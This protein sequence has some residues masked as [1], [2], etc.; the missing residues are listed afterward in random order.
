MWYVVGWVVLSV[1]V[2][3]A[4]DAWLFHLKEKPKNL[5]DRGRG[6]AAGNAL[7]RVQSLIDP[8]AESAIEVRESE[9]VEEDDEGAPPSIDDSEVL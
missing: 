1:L 2:V 4:I 8:S 5:E 6:A 9:A 7:L 3:W